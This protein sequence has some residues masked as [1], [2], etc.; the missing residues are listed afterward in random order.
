MPRLP[1]ELLRELLVG[2]LESVRGS[3]QVPGHALQTLDGL[4]GT[5]VELLV[6]SLELLTRHVGDVAAGDELFDLALELAQAVLDVGL[7]CLEPAAAR[8]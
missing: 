2:L 6:G 3:L 4:A 5:L 8:L 7:T 1:V